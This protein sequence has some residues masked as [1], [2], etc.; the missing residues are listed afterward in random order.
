MGAIA[1]DDRAGI[2]EA[3]LVAGF[4]EAGDIDIDKRERRRHLGERPAAPG[5]LEGDHAAGGAD[6]GEGF[7][8]IG[9]EAGE[10][11]EVADE[12]QAGGG[13]VGQLAADEGQIDRRRGAAMVGKA[14]LPAGI[15]EDGGR[16]RG[17]VFTCLERVGCDPLPRE[18]G[19]D[20][21]A[22]HISAD[23]ARRGDLHPQPGHRRA[24][25]ADDA[26]GGD[27]DRIDMEELAGTRGD[28]ERD[29][30]NEDV[31]DAGAAED[32]VARGAS[33]EGSGGG[34]GR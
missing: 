21:V 22:P 8:E 10:E 26:A 29:G 15:D 13:E 4:V 24:G 18:R 3:G 25:V 33:P 7:G 30:A 28:R 27:P 9:L 32:H 12:G 11:P 5:R 16:A 19:A 17:D 34:T 14:P 20:H 31:G 1:G 23:E 6:L 2:V